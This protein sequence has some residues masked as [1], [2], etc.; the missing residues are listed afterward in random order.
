VIRARVGAMVAAV[1]VL[2]ACGPV[3]PRSGASGSRDENSTSRSGPALEGTTGGTATVALDQVPTTLNDHTVAGDTVSGHFVASAIWP[4]VFQVGPGQTP[5]LDTSVVLS[6]ELVSV[7]PQTVVYQINP[8]ALWSDGT[9][10]GSEDF[11][12]A[13]QSQRGGATDVDGSPD[14]VASTLGYRDISSVTGSN[15]GRTVTVVFHTDFGDWESLFDDLLPAHIAE[16]VGWNQGFDSFDPSTLVSGGPWQVESWQ[17]G[18]QI[19][20][21]RNSRWWGPAPHLDRIVVDATSGQGAMVGALRSGE[22]D[23]GYSSTFDSASLAQ[24]SSTPDLETRESLGTTM[25][26]LVFNVRHPPLDN[27]AVRQ[28]IAHAIDRAGIITTLV[29]PLNGS[30]WEDNDYLFANTQ[31]QYVDDGAGYVQADPATADRLLSQGGL[32]ADPTGTWTLHGAP[33]TLNLA[34]AQ[35]NPWSALVAPAIAAQLVNAGFDVTTDPVTTSQLAAAVLPTGAFDLA[36]APIGASAYPT[37]TTEYFSSASS[38]TGSTA[39]RDWSGFSDP[40]LDALFAQAA[41]TLGSNQSQPLYRQL[42]QEL[43]ADMPALPLFD[44]PTLLVNSAWVNGVTDDPGGLGP[45]LSATKWFRV[46]SVSRNKSRST[47]AQ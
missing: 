13:W 38:V 7:S 19:V 14:S 43:W 39:N 11:I 9:P 23:I 6:A 10:I 36:I 33:V 45:F 21:G 5:V 17:P 31:P 37:A 18:S 16:R 2:A 20:L 41:E 24:V 28:G 44:E 26:Q 15:G 40:R 22:A 12:Y 30:I 32:V 29:Q 47:S 42:D 35:D 46:V 3:A 25:L 8:K 1:V 4:Q 34:W 27:T